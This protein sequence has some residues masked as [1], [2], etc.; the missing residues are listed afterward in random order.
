M[1]ALDTVSRRFVSSVAVALLVCVCVSAQNTRNVLVLHE[2]NANH[3]ANVI[4]SRVFHEIFGS[5]LRNQFFEEYMDE[6]R[7]DASDERLEESL[8]KKYGANTINLLIADGQPALRFVLRRGE[9]LWPRTPK[10]FYFVDFRELPAK[11]PPNMTGVASNLDH[12]PILDL[13]LQLRPNTRH[14]FY[15]G[16]V[17]PWEQTWRGF[18]EQDFKRFTGRVDI[19]YLNDLPFAELL[20]RL[21]RLPDNSAVIYSELLQDA[22]GHVYVPGRVCPLIASASNAPVYGP[23]DTYVGC[24]IVGGPILDI[25]DVAAQTARLGIR[26]LERGTAT[27]F[28]VESSRTRVEID[29][30]QLQH[31]GISEKSLPA[32][33]VVLFRP[34]SLWD[35]YKWFITAGLATMVVQ[36]LLIINLLREMRR[37]KKSD[38]AVKNLTGRLINAGEEERKRIARELHDDIVQRLSVVSIGLKLIERKSPMKAAIAHISMDEPLQQLSEI[39][40]DIHNLSHQLHSRHLE[41]LGLEVALEDLCQQLSKQHDV[42]IRLTTDKILLP[43]PQN[44][45]LCFFRIAQE[46]LNNSVKHSG[47]ARVEVGLTTCD[48]MLS[49]TIKDFGTG[50]DV[51]VPANGL[52]LATMQERLRLVDGTLLINSS[53]GGGTEVTAQVR[54]GPHLRP[55][56]TDEEHALAGVGSAVHPR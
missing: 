2:G 55:A 6:D 10:L 15:V 13:A 45:A 41:M 1:G 3:P 17:N 53:Q 27:G 43:L 12:G 52:G 39:I 54:L 19:T 48:G 35:Q 40:S 26:V 22:S 8:E 49:L 42:A 21:G 36:L 38:L 44:L 4:S 46:A 7:L 56:T 32:G 34:P 18:A 14:A 5:D 47:S 20:D 25:G 16:G 29:W 51:S 28:P 23:F 33:T 50:F 11:L 24:G 9:K 30:R 31:W 37:R